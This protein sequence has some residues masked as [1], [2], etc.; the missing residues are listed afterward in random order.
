MAQRNPNRVLPPEP[1]RRPFPLTELIIV[2]FFVALCLAL[3]G[4][5]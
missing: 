3:W 4:A 5:A 1:P 2:L